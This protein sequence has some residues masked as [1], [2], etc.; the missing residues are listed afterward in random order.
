[1]ASPAP[2]RTPGSWETCPSAPECPGPIIFGQRE[3]W[4]SVV[5]PHAVRRHGV[6]LLFLKL[7]IGNLLYREDW[8]QTALEVFPVAYDRIESIWWQKVTSCFKFGTV[9]VKSE[10]TTTV[11]SP[12]L[13]QHGSGVDHRSCDLV[14]MVGGI[15][16]KKWGC[17][18]HRVDYFSPGRFFLPGEIPFLLLLVDSPEVITQGKLFLPVSYV[19][20]KSAPFGADNLFFPKSQS[21]A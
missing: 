4:F 21:S 7:L 12:L 10:E 6:E 20:P 3:G 19:V 16:W 14:S 13:H 2:P 17:S 15:F 18:L 5:G 1:M 8:T 9:W 11:V